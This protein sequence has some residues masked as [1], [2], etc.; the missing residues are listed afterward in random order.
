MLLFALWFKCF[1][2]LFECVV[3]VK[4]FEFYDQATMLKLVKIQQI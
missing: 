1:N 2:R 3:Q 4:S